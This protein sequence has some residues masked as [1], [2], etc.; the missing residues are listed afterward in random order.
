MTVNRWR[1][2]GPRD[3]ESASG[4]TI[5][6]A[7]SARERLLVGVG[8]TLALL[9]A[10][11]AAQALVEIHLSAILDEPR[12]YCID[13]LGY[14][15][16]ARTDGALQAHTCYSYQGAIAVDQGI[17]RGEVGSRR[18]RFAHFGVCMRIEHAKSGAALLLEECKD[19]PEQSFGFTP[20]GE[21]R[22]DA[23]P[24]LCVTIAPGFGVAGGGGQPVHLRR[25]LFLD[26]CA[27]PAAARQRWQLR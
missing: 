15:E 17:D 6:I 9:S 7:C 25:S 23:A 2:P 3:G 12:G 20:A 19:S 26:A 21:I 11:A 16:R 18:F 14:K 24:E 8:V 1:R 10:S 22:P 5:A 27:G 4:S 13:M